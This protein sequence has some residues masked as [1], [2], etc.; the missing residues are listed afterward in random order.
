MS[1]LSSVVRERGSVLSVS[2][3][4]YR[5]SEAVLESGAYL[6]VPLFYHLG[7]AVDLLSVS[8]NCLLKPFGNSPCWGGQFF[9]N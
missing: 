4:V 8:H 1:G 3:S 5:Q 2:E 7:W 9:A 6:A